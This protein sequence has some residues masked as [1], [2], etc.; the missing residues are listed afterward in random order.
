MGKKKNQ[1]KS[2]DAAENV[3]VEKNQEAS[4]QDSPVEE[5]AS[6]AAAES[7]AAQTETNAAS[8]T[9]ASPSASTKGTAQKTVEAAVTVAKDVVK[10][11]VDSI[12]TQ[13]GE[14]NTQKAIDF[15]NKAKS[16]VVEAVDF[17]KETVEDAATKA[18]DKATAKV[19]EVRD[20]AT[21][22]VT[23]ARDLATTKA[24]ELKDKT[25]AKAVEVKDKA[26]AKVTETVDNLKQSERV[27][28][29][30]KKANEATLWLKGE[31]AETPLENT[32][33]TVTSVVIASALAASSAALGIVGLKNSATNAVSSVR[34]GV[35][36]MATKNSVQKVH[37]FAN[38][39]W[40]YQLAARMIAHVD[41]SVLERLAK[42]NGASNNTN[43][44]PTP[45]KASAPSSIE[46]VAK[47]A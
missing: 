36:G 30:A 3:E 12:K 37:N 15:A 27:Q 14:E 46:P 7:P 1:T 24:V 39:Y 29:A 23:E 33:V 32:T 26:T 17:A 34:H 28:G 18:K 20:K 38:Q 5:V 21:A 31:V 16:E 45:T 35:T 40:P 43:S 2:N 8:P 13:I 41:A 9:D 47:T 22:K 25:T 11:T 6:P 19:T 4:S 10:A 42:A 44:I